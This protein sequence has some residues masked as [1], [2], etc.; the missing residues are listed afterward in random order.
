MVTAFCRQLGWKNLELL[1]SQFQDR[2]HFGIHSELLELMKLPSLNGIRA[3][4]LFDSGFETISSIASADINNI[5]NILHKSVPFQSEKAREDD[6]NDDIRKRNKMKSVWITGYCGITIKE[7]AENLIKEARKHLSHEIGVVDIQWDSKLAEETEAKVKSKREKSG[8]ETENCVSENIPDDSH[9]IISD[10]KSQSSI[11]LGS[12]GQNILMDKMEKLETFKTEMMET[13]HETENLIFQK[14][15]SQSTL[16]K[17]LKEKE[18]KDNHLSNHKIDLKHLNNSNKTYEVKENEYDT[19]LLESLRNDF[20]VNNSEDVCSKLST[21]KSQVPTQEQINC[22]IAKKV[23]DKSTD[24]TSFTVKDSILWDSLNFTENGLENITKIRTSNKISPNV[25]FGEFEKSIGAGNS[26]TMNSSKLNVSTKDISLFSSEGDNSS[27]FE[28]SLPIDLIS[29]NLLD[30]DSN[31]LRKQETTSD[32]A[33]IDSNTLLNAFKTTLIEVEDSEEDDIKLVYEDDVIVENELLKTPNIAEL[34]EKIDKNYDS[35]KRS[36]NLSKEI[37]PLFKKKKTDDEFVL[38]NIKET[39]KVK[40]SSFNL[41]TTNPL[42]KR[43]IIEFNKYELHYYVLRGNDIIDNI[44][45]IEDV[46]LASIYLLLNQR[47][48]TSN[49]IIGSEVIDNAK[50]KKMIASN[51]ISPVKGISIFFRKDKCIYLDFTS[52]GDMREIKQSLK[53]WFQK[54]VL[55]KVLCSK[56]VNMILKKW[57]GVNLPSYCLDISLFEW[58][59][60]STEKVPDIEYLVKYIF[61]SKS[62]IS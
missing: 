7:A 9:K 46:Q 10:N 45:V 4:T 14:K 25:S 1:I 32:Y 41:K 62:C 27:L 20:N 57:L 49:E 5:E 17:P 48:G 43:F 26:E 51:E 11:C 40:S 56:T 38:S 44:H 6:D 50:Y 34:N 2:L 55:F 8:A 18:L 12:T 47:I 60:D 59:I 52:V 16:F 3:R 22:N 36:Y 58:L 30:K 15:T 33:S 19:K 31:I 61:F 23:N 37:E 35:C 28:D 39:S 21:T 29:S 53:C 13:K 24:N 42:S 54:K